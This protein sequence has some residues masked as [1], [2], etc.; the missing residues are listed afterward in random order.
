[1]NSL[2]VVKRAVSLLA[3]AACASVSAQS[4]NTSAMHSGG[5]SY[6]SGGIGLDDRAQMESSAQQFNAR[7]MFAEHD[8]AFVVADTVIVSR[9][10][11]EVMRVSD[12]GPLLYLNLPNGTYTVHATYMGVP[13]NRTISVSRRTPDVVI[14]WPTA[15]THWRIR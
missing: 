12:V 11:V 15:L 6:M 13:R 4:I 3:I 7:L 9:G 10:N 8:G 5:V 1:M 2:L 14:S